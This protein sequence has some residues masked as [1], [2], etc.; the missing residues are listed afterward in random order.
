M[1]HIYY[2]SITI[3]GFTSDKK[4][5]SALKE[6]LEGELWHEHATVGYPIFREVP[7]KEES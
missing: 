3:D 4:S 1:K 5:I 7:E 2:F 6:N